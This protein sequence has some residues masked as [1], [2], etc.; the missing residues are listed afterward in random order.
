MD[1]RKFMSQQKHICFNVLSDPNWHA[2]NIYIFNCIHALSLL[3][4][5]ERNRI[6]ISCA[7]RKL[8]DIP[9]EIQ[10]KI[11][12]IF[13]ETTFHIIFYKLLKI[14]PSW[15][16]LSIFNFRK[17]DF[18]Y[19]GGNLPKKWIFP[20]GG[21]IPDFQYRYL[22]HLFSKQEFEI[23]EKRSLHAAKEAPILAFSSNCAMNDYR[24]FFPE[25]GGNEFLLRFVSNANKQWMQKDAKEVQQKFHLPDTFFIVCN[26]FW[27]H[28]DHGTV[29]E[30]IA[31]LK[32]EGIKITV[33]CTGATEDFRNPD[34]FPGLITKAKEL[35]VENQFVVLGFISRED[36]IQLI[37]RSLAIIQPSL[38]EG[39]STVVEDGRSLG[40]TIFLSDFEVHR[41]QNPPHSIFF[42]QGDAGQLATLIKTNLP[43]LEPG[44]DELLEEVAYQENQL[45]MRA[46]GAEIVKMAGKSRNQ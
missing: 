25:Y 9:E 44:P 5:E 23:R 36:Q 17:I 42:K 45:L 35:G 46:F 38:F 28:K 33:A 21:W 39:W 34:Y 8:S 20:W 12:R 24:K 16:R 18:Y 1:E 27:K 13:I 30:A 14:A 43:N 3:P 6:T 2:G 4:T 41:E 22:P 7:T 29:I 11:D 31:I 32:E 10:Q 37:R 15:L 26:Q 19:P 40:K